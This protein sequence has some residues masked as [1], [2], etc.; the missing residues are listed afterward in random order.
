MPTS[1]KNRSTYG[2]LLRRIIIRQTER[3]ENVSSDDDA[4]K[5]GSNIGYL[6]DKLNNLL[7]QD[8]AKLAQR[9]EELEKIAGIAQKNMIAK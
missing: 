8:E 1:W 6:I 3:F 4:V 2:K 9:I 7:K 5:L